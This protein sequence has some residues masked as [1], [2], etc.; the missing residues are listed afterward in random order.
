MPRKHTQSP[1]SSTRQVVDAITDVTSVKK[2]TTNT[3][4]QHYDSAPDL[5]SIIENI[6]ERKKRKFDEGDIYNTDIIKEMFAVL[7]RDQAARFDELQTT[8]SCLKEQNVKLTQSV[9]MM[10]SKYDEFLSRISQ[11]ESD[12]RTDKKYIELLEDK[13]EYSER[14]SRSTGIEIRNIP[15]KTG[16][17]KHDLFNLINSVAKIADVDVNPECIK[18]IYRIKS[19]D[20]S[21]PI[22]VELTT[23]LLKEKILNNLK[24][25]NKTKRPG[26]KL[27][28]GNL[29]F[30]GP[31][32]PVYVSEAL[33]TK[34]QKLF[35]LARTFQQQYKYLFCWTSHGVIYLRKEENAPHIKILSEKDIEN[36]RK[37]E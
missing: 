13:I 12:R 35:Y 17:T 10:S 36:L 3:A 19:R 27:N 31:T 29:G 28:T 25:Y 20:S 4:I 34:T 37:L 21:H 18:D 2:S 33:T 14:K 23:V 22:M 8:I 16:E 26:E 6:N 9:E 11:L 5:R 1:P 30:R 7:S 15:K 32:K 24:S